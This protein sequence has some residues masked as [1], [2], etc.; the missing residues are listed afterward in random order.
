M[1]QVAKLSTF[2]KFLKI[3][4]SKVGGRGPTKARLRAGRRHDVGVLLAVEDGG[5]VEDLHA[6]DGLPV[7][8]DLGNVSCTLG[9]FSWT[10]GVFSKILWA[11][12]GA[13]V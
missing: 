6:A 7:L 5:A 3:H 9:A 11:T 10:L 8:V 4:V 12:L 2:V 13:L 1:V